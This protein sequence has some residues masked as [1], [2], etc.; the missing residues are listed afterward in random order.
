MVLA[1]TACHSVLLAKHP[2]EFPGDFIVLFLGRLHQCTIGRCQDLQDMLRVPPPYIF[3]ACI[4]ALM[5]AGLYFF[6]HSVASQLA[7]QKGI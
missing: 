1:W 3:A 5:I 6:D 2:L 4:P 7:Q